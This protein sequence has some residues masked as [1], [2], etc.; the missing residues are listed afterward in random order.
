MNYDSQANRLLLND[1]QGGYTETELPGETF[2]TTIAAVGDFNGNGAIGIV[3]GN[4]GAVNQI[5]M[6]DGTGSF[7]A[8]NLLSAYSAVSLD[9]VILTRMAT[10]T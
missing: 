8:T 10:L 5:L 4:Y 7:V 2:Q 6:N 1:G 3:F 9:T